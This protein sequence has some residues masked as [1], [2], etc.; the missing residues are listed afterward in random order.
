VFWSGDGGSVGVGRVYMSEDVVESLRTGDA[1]S[2]VQQF[3]SYNRTPYYES[4]LA[5]DVRRWARKSFYRALLEEFTRFRCFDRGK[6]LL[7]FL[8]ENDQRR[9]MALFFENIDVNRIEYQMPFFDGEF[10]AAAAALN[11]DSTLRH[12]FY[13]KHWLPRFGPIASEVAWQAYPGHE[14]CPLPAPKQAIYQWGGDTARTSGNARMK[15]AKRAFRAAVSP[16]L[17]TAVLSRGRLM[18]LG[19]SAMLTGRDYDYAFRA[20]ETFCR[21]FS[22]DAPKESG[23]GGR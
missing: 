5:R 11:L 2:A 4:M 19:V 17:P 13:V 8:L 1:E 12:R 15:A 10:L 23:S 18:A 7:L 14:P 21:Y 20:V 22:G 6:A 3:L 9:H 16:S